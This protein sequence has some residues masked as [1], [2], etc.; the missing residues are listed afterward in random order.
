MAVN[1]SA[2]SVR[3]GVTGPN[4]QPRWA[5]SPAGLLTVIAELVLKSEL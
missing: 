1:I 5:G 4:E 2:A 3:G